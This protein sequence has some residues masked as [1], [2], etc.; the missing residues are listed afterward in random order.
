MNVG[1]VGGKSARDGGG[2]LMREEIAVGM[3][4]RFSLL[5]KNNVW[6]M[7]GEEECVV[8]MITT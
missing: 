3:M 7:F 8:E 4:E 1:L 5:R 2:R 6:V